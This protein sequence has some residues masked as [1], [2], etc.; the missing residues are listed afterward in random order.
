MAGQGR[1]RATLLTPNRKATYMVMTDWE[2]RF[3]WTKH[4]EPQ[5]CTDLPA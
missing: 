4:L 1:A 2:M 3:N 5:S